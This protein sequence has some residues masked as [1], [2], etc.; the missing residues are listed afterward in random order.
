MERVS[1]LPK[2]FERDQQRTSFFRTLHFLINVYTGQFIL[3]SLV[4]SDW[5]IIF[6]MIAISAKKKDISRNLQ[7]DTCMLCRDLQKYDTFDPIIKLS[8]CLTLTLTCKKS[9]FIKSK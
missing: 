7:H 5:S 9:G 8:V 6:L 4:R 2:S 3:K 1:V